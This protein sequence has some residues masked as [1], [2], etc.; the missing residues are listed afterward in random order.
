[1]MSHP[2]MVAGPDRFDTLLMKVT[3][4]RIVV[5]GGAEGFMGMAVMPGAMG[6]DSPTLGIAMKVSDGDGR[7]R[8]RPAVCLEILRQLDAL[9]SEELK[10][11]EKFGPAG[12]VLNRRD[13]IVGKKGPAFTLKIEQE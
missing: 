1:M 11:L 3:K 10:K 13:L 5:K 2:D 4:G 9:S 7:G 6:V 8:T 12:D